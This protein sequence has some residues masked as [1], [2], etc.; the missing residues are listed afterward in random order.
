MIIK[1][2][3][4]QQKFF[5]L[6]KGANYNKGLSTGFRSM[7]ERMKLAKGYMSII[8]GYPSSGKSELLDAI[9]VNMAML[10]SQW[11]TLY[12]SPENHPI[13]QHM[14]KLAEK[15]IGKPAFEFTQQETEQA[16]QWLQTYFT[17][18]YPEKPTLETILGLAQEV[19]ETSN[20]DALVIDPW[21]EVLHEKS[22]FNTADYLSEALM[23]VRRFAR[24]HDIHVF[25]VAHPKLP[26]LDKNGCYPKPDMYSI[27]DGAMWRNKADYGWAAHRP[28]LSKHEI[29]FIMLKNKYKWQG[30]IMQSCYFDY[31]TKSGRFKE[32]TDEFFTIPEALPF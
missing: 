19:A 23:K 20:L 3:S 22:H 32:K 12:Y 30:K 16:L 27:A 7:D 5:D 25:I 8:T 1:P 15:L 24:H 28:D 4:L 21:N 31:D 11:K 29:E 18:I 17:W 26:T 14:S 6:R 13:E 10:E 2:L 9:L